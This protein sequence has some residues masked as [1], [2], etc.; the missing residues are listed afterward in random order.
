MKK[1]PK[2]EVSFKASELQD[3]TERQRNRVLELIYDDAAKQNR[4]EDSN[5]IPRSTR[6]G[7]ITTAKLK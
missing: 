7:I 2:T 4:T 6:V 1:I 3:L 5:K